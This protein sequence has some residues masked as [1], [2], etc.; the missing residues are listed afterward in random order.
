MDC[1]VL[2]ARELDLN[3]LGQNM[4]VGRLSLLQEIFPTQ[5]WNPGL[6]HFRQILSQLSHKGNPLRDKCWV[7]GKIALLRKPVMLGRR[8]THIP[9]NKLPAADLGARVFRG[10]FQGVI[11]RGK[12]LYAEQHGPDS[13]LEIGHV[14]V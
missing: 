8:W 2:W 12:E 13:H 3:S 14:V 9:K 11:G 6:L 1:I 7:K 10:E 4:G 5:G